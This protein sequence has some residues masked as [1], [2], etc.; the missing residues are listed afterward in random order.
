MMSREGPSV[1]L[2]GKDSAVGSDNKD[3]QILV[4]QNSIRTVWSCTV[5]SNAWL[6]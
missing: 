4:S 3:A 2:A 6:Q 1:Y 5:Q